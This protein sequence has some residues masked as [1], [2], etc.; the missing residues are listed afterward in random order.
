LNVIVA[1]GNYGWPDSIGQMGRAGVQRPFIDSGGSTWAPSGV[2]FQQDGLLV[3]ALAARMLFAWRQG[4]ASLDRVFTSG[5]RLRDVL[6]VQGDVYLITTNSSPRPRTST[7]GDRLLRL[8][9][10]R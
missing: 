2:A 5:D 8:S 9:P 4:A 10:A 3:A 6:P 1:G 7:G